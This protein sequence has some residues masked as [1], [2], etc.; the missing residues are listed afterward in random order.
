MYSPA[1][2]LAGPVLATAK[3]ALRLTVVLTL[4][5][6]LE[7]VGSAGDWLPTEAVLASV[8]AAVLGLIWARIRAALV[9]PLVRAPT[10]RL[11]PQ[12]EP[13]LGSQAELESTQ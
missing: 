10:A 12:L 7:P 8:P 5:L 6:S 11:P 3:S 1:F 2:A 4:E 9:A 13:L